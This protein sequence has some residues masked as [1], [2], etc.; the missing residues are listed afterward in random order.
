[1][2]DDLEHHETDPL[3]DRDQDRPMN[4]YRCTKCGNRGHNARTCGLTPEER[5]ERRRNWRGKK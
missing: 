1:M 3:P 2:S 4:N 5:I